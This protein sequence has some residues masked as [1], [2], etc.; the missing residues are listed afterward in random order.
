MRNF[1]III[2]LILGLA[3]CSPNIGPAE[4]PNSP[5]PSNGAT[6]ISVTGINLSWNSIYLKGDQS[7]NSNCDIYFGSNSANIPQLASGVISPYQIST[8]LDSGKTYY[9]YVI[10]Y[11]ENNDTTVGPSW[12]FTTV[13]QETNSAPN[14]PSNPS[15]SNG[16]SN[17]SID[18]SLSWTGG[19]P[20]PGDTVKYYVYFGTSSNPPL[21]SSNL[22]NTS[23]N[24]GALNYS[25]TY[26]WKISAKDNHGSTTDGAIWSFATGS[27]PNSPPAKPSK[28][29]TNYSWYYPNNYPYYPDTVVIS[30]KFPNDPDN[31][32]MY[33]RIDT[34]DGYISP[35]SD[36]HAFIG[37][38]SILLLTGT[39]NNPSEDTGTYY[40]LKWQVK[41]I[42]ENLSEWSDT[43]MV[44]VGHYNS[45]YEHDIYVNSSNSYNKYFYMW[46]KGEISRIYISLNSGSSFN[47]YLYDPNLNIVKQSTNATIVDWLFISTNS[48]EGYWT[49]VVQKTIGDAYIDVW[50]NTFQLPPGFTDKK[51]KRR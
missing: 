7:I 22:A 36:P 3:S 48:K 9:W 13:E 11:N 49:V 16:A 15:P 37:G 47:A 18:V 29:V 35:W 33:Y 38:D 51:W 24:P 26:Y 46:D 17:Q 27:Q 41:D 28:L 12:H 50:I 4:A 23:Y 5:S 2:L 39:Y 32:S 43:K 20:D 6:G 45:S 14:T 10:A 31:D 19:D 42:H 34:G 8:T 30:G 1:L 40:G 25:V 44:A 21:V